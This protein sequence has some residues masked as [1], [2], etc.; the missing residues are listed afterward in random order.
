MQKRLE[1]ARARR[2]QRQ[3]R[4]LEIRLGMPPD[5]LSAPSAFPLRKLL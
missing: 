5:S 3:R 2:E 4:E 1:R